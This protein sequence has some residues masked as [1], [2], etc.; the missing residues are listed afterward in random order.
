[1][2]ETRHL[3]KYNKQK[4]LADL[5][6]IDRNSILDPFSNNQVKM[7][8]TFQES[9]ESL[10]ETHARLKTKMLRKQNSPWIT[11]KIRQDMEKRDELQKLA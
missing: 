4:F 9:F 6:Q 1:M 5:Q 7:A 11:S 8:S 2:I 3:R 10:L